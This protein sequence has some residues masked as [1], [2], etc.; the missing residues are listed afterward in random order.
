M[1]G[2]RS[3]RYA[4]YSNFS[5]RASL[6]GNFNQNTFDKRVSWTLIWPWRGLLSWTMRKRHR[7]TSVFYRK[8][9]VLS[10]F[11]RKNN[12]VDDKQQQG[13]NLV[14]YVTFQSH[15]MQFKLYIL[16]RL[17]FLT[18][19][20]NMIYHHLLNNCS[21]IVYLQHNSG[22]KVGRASKQWKKKLKN[23][24]IIFLITHFLCS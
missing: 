11:I 5:N 12:D 19:Q 3:W 9:F 1:T 18:V 10:Y 23:N 7:Q 2:S 4:E 15:R 16:R 6:I 17:T 13:I 24:L 21:C 8:Q 22:K 20:K 14:L